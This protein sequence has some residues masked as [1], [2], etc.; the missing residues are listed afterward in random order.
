MLAV[1][2]PQQQII[3]SP[4][5]ESSYDP[6][7]WLS[8]FDPYAALQSMVDN[9][10]TLPGSRHE[11]HT[12]RAYLGSLADFCRF[13]GA[14]VIH[15]GGETYD[16]IFSQMEM[17]T[18]PLMMNYMAYCKRRGLSSNTITRYL[19]SIKHFLRALDEQPVA[20]QSGGDYIFITEA[21]RHFTQAVRVKGP[22][23]DRTSNRPAL[24]QY[25][26][27]LTLKQVNQLLE[28]FQSEIHTITGKRDL[29]LFYLGITSGLRAAE[30]ARLTL[31]SIT[32]GEDC[33]EIRVRGKRSN[34]DPVGI[35]STAYTLIQ[36]YVTAFNDRANDVGAQR[37][38][39]CISGP[40]PIFQPLLR[41][42]HI[43]PTGLHGYNPA[44]GISA[45]AILKIVERRTLDALGSSITAHDMRRTC[46]Y[47]MRQSGFEWDQIRAQL[48][49]R[50]IGT[51]E[52]YVG[53]A[54]DLSSALL[55]KRIALLVPQESR[56]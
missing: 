29:A 21:R 13:C 47:L 27:R 41:G 28:S 51:T 43:P 14:Y 6:Y 30:I 11:R 20:L 2:D 38:A 1:I 50:S 33:Y 42:D 40:V 17:P 53:Q 56:S 44:L 7:L 25:G 37:A 16:F 48:R 45:R 22:S 24:E 18:K 34:H 36:S 15:N 19:A 5:R 26:H 12:M 39:P 54:Q 23:P 8:Y 49:H 35:D 55:S 10:E 32:Q 4:R 31:D 46:A 3:S 52:K 9:V